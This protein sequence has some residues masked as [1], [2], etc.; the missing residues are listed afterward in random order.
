MHWRTGS[1]M[2]VGYRDVDQ[3]TMARL[4]DNYGDARE[5]AGGGPQA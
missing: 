4:V 1:N 2:H 3:G 5:N